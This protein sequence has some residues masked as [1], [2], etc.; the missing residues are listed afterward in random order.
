MNRQEQPRYVALRLA[1]EA[2]LLAKAATPAGWSVK[3]FGGSSEALS[4]DAARM[5]ADGRLFRAPSNGGYRYFTTLTLVKAFEESK[6][7]APRGRPAGAGTRNC[8]DFGVDDKATI[9]PG[10][11]VQYAPRPRGR[12]EV[13]GKVIG[14]FVTEWLT[15]RGASA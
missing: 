10:V 12:F 3:D 6:R 5:L 11:Q 14:G 8:A 15:L 2:R 13:D 9:P 1:R 7:T 4:A